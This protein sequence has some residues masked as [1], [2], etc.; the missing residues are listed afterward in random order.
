MDGSFNPPKKVGDT[1][2]R[3]ENGYGI[4]NQEKNIKLAMRLLGLQNIFR[5]ELMAIHH[6]LTIINNDFPNEP[7]HIFTD[8]LNG[9]YVIKRTK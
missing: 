7:I 5:A 8:C 9:L 4:Y 1:W 6:A 3:E 2:L